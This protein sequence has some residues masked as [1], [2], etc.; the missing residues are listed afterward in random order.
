MPALVTN[1]FRIHNAKQFVEA[2]DEVSF[3]SGTAVTDTSG[4][5]NS[6]MYLFIGRPSAWPDDN[7]PPTPTDSV[8]N[9]HYDNW[10]DMIAAKKVTSSDVSHCIPI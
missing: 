4:L 8:A 10:R 2:F 5:L 9:T 3:T 1:K 7:T 6:N